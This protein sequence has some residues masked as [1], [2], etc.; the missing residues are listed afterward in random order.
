MSTSKNVVV[1]KDDQLLYELTADEMVVPLEFEAGDTTAVA[2]FHLD[3][4]VSAFEHKVL[5]SAST[6]RYKR[7]ESGGGRELQITD[8][9]KVQAFISKHFRTISGLDGEYTSEQI[10]EWLESNPQI[11]SRLYREGYDRVLLDSPPSSSKL[12]L[13]ISPEVKTRGK[14]ILALEDTVVTVPFIHTTRKETELDRLKHRKALKI[15][16]RGQY[17]D[18]TLN[19]DVIEQLYNDLILSVEGF[20]VKGKACTKE[21][22]P[23][24]VGL[25]PFPDKA[26]VVGRV[27]NAS[28][29]KNE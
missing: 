24:W 21:N 2:F 20:L 3:A 27:F 25:I 12:S 15:S 19:W 14:R 16:E 1:Q 4:Q 5:A 17:Q 23:D 10:R 29:L 26:F 18:H 22:K 9:D 7:A 6:L 28:A 8:D 13:I 11:K